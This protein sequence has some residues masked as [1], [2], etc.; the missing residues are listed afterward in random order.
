MRGPYTQPPPCT[1]V[2]KDALP[3]RHVLTPLHLTR[4]G[5]TPPASRRRGVGPSGRALAG[6]LPQ[7]PSEGP[8]GL[9][10]EQ[11][12]WELPPWYLLCAGPWL[13]CRKGSASQ[14]QPEPPGPPAVLS[15]CSRAPAPGAGPLDRGPRKATC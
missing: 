9:G 7:P 6:H 1:H 13:R 11:V 10:G 8:R 2:H 3:C 12:R 14:M 5:E 4:G 15:S